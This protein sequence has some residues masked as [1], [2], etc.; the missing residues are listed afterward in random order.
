[1][2]KSRTKKHSPS[3]AVG[4]S[5]LTALRKA[6]GRATGD[7]FNALHEMEGK[8]VRAVG[9]VRRKKTGKTANDPR[10]KVK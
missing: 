5:M 9:L 4:M 10:R 7:V 2:P 3:K 6:K 1:M 8:L